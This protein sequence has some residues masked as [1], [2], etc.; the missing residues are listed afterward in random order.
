MYIFCTRINRSQQI[1]HLNCLFSQSRTTERKNKYSQSINKFYVF[2]NNRK[3]V[4]HDT[5]QQK[6]KTEYPLNLITSGRLVVSSVV[7]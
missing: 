6:K 5:T 2:L 1:N 7:K 4:S 3:N